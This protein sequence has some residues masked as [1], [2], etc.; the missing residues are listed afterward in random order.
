MMAP[1]APHPSPALC[2]NL[3]HLQSRY[4]RMSGPS[5]HKP[6]IMLLKTSLRKSLNTVTNLLSY[7]LSLSLVDLFGPVAHAAALQHG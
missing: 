1:G 4:E 7:I 6:F 5:L 3:L 2:D